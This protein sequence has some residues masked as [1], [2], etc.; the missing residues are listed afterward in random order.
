MTRVHLAVAK[1]NGGLPG[2]LGYRPDFQYL[3][4]RKQLTIGFDGIL[5]LVAT[6]LQMLVGH[7]HIFMNLPEPR[8][9]IHAMFPETQFLL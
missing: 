4:I 6:V 9:L 8:L 5:L 3:A 1:A 2:F 7:V